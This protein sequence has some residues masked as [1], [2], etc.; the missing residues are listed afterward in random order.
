M[1]NRIRTRRAVSALAASALLIWTAAGGAT[2]T[3]PQCERATL[4][5][6]SCQAGVRCE[7]TYV[8]ASVMTD[9]PGGYQWDCGI[10]RPA[11]DPPPATLDPWLGPYPSSIGIDRTTI[12]EL[13]PAPRPHDLTHDRD[14]ERT[15]K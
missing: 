2:E 7:C 12:Y 8:R 13:P 5:Q 11:C 14:R 1:S 9:R 15:R 6:L 3:P 4:G 10:N